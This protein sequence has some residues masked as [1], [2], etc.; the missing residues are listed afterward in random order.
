MLLETR[1]VAEHP[2]KHKTALHNSDQT[3]RST[4][5]QQKNPI[6]GGKNKDKQKIQI[7]P[8]EGGKGKSSERTH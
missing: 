7:D 6:R 1:D 8:E 2:W 5:L 4:V 3:R